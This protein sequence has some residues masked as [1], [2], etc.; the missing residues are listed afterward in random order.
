MGLSCC[1]CRIH[2]L[3]CVSVCVH[4]VFMCGLGGGCRGVWCACMRACVT[5]IQYNVTSWSHSALVIACYAVSASIKLKYLCL[6][7]DMLVCII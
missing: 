4:E 6:C 1:A 3:V 7:V 2:T 5:V